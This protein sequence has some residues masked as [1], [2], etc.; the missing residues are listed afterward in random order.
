MSPRKP[1]RPAAS[2]AHLIVGED[3]YLRL[4]KREEIIADAVPADARDFAV[5][6]VSLEKTALTQALALAATL[7]M[8]SPRQVL[9]LSDVDAVTD[10][11]LAQ[12]ETYLDDPAGFT[13]LVFEARKLDGRTRVAKLLLARCELFEAGSTNESEALRAAREFAAELSLKLSPETFEDLVFALGTDQGRLRV[14]LEKLKAYAGPK[15]QVTSGDVADLVIPARLFN[16]FDLADL[17]AERRRANA[18]ARLRRLLEAGENPIGIVG[19]LSWLYRQLLIAQSLPRN[20]PPWKAGQALR[21]PRSK[22]PDLLRQARRFS[23]RELREGFTALL[24]ADVALKSGAANPV[25]ILEAMVVRLT[26][27]SAAS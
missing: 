23:A 5:T 25:A 19:A 8:L 18:L 14:E 27:G 11:D 4:R 9:V 22:I 15:G 16:V 20:I 21:A 13:V 10:E 7:P 17:L 26:A 24:D 3:D 2:G 12:L 6:Q 1:R